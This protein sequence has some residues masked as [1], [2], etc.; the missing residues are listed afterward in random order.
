MNF[1]YGSTSSYIEIYSKNL[2]YKIRQGMNSIENINTFFELI[3]RTNMTFSQNSEK[4]LQDYYFKN[5]IINYCQYCYGNFDCSKN[6]QM[7]NQYGKDFRKLSNI[8]TTTI[9]FQNELNIYFT[10]ISSDCY[11]S[12]C[13]GSNF[14]NF[15]PSSRKWFQNHL[16]QINSSQFVISEPY[17]NFLGGV[18]ISGTTSIY[19]QNKSVIGIGAIDLNFSQFYQFNYEDIDLLV[20]DNQ[21]RILISSYYY[22]TQT[23]DVLSLQNE[24]IFGFNQTDVNQI[25]SQNQTQENCL[26]NIPNT[27]CIINKNTNELWY[28]RS[29]NIT[30]EYI[31]LLK[32][33]SQAYS[34]YIS[35]LKNMIEEMFQSLIGHLIIG[36][37]FTTFISL[38]IHLISFL[39]LQ[40]P[41]DRLINSFNKYLLWGKQINFNLFCDGSQDQLDRLSDAFLRL[42][43]QSKSNQRNK[44]NTIKQYLQESQYPINYYVNSKIMNTKNRTSLESFENQIQKQKL[45][46]QFFDLYRQQICKIEN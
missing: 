45:V 39:L 25:I 12:T 31:I 38:C 26:L 34:N 11:F 23:K 44:Q 5:S 16:D 10:S 17:V 28:I 30:D 19:D 36:I 24:S 35:L 6:I 33:N 4:C 40:K 37:V 9:A 27:I 22:K 7:Q 15:V 20:I 41:I 1:I 43:N 18:Y 46:Q 42:I 29:K 8:L 21:G 3:Q 14:T 32:F 2:E 13:P